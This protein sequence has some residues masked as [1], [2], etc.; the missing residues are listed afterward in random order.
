MSNNGNVFDEVAEQ[1]VV[2]VLVID[3]EQDAVP[4]ARAL[5][6]GGIRVMELTLRT[7]AAMG[8]LKLIRSQVPEMIAGIGTIL[9]PDQ[10]RAVADADGSFGVSPGL[11]ETVLETARDC[12]L[13]F[14]PG[15]LTPS[16]I[17]NALRHDLRLLKFF[18][19][20]PSGGLNYLNA[21]AA[22]YQHLGVRFIPL[23]GLNVENMTNYL[24]NP[25][26]AA[27]GG[28]WIAQREAILAGDWG[29][30]TTRAK[31]AVERAAPPIASSAQ[32]SG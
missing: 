21:V 25:A 20:E 5:L 30:I 15:V 7:E 1:R 12:G 31:A 24:A 26:V 13:P 16:D 28:S 4:L 29:T 9:T 23:G 6:A 11:S 10:V 27:I 8:A 14:A 19:V 18:P 32:K 22:P 17:E 3:R 2:A